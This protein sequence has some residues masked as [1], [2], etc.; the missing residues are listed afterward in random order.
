M[1]VTIQKQRLYIKEE[2]LEAEKY[3]LKPTIHWMD[4]AVV[5]KLQ[6]KTF[7]TDAEAK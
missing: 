3:K 2:N 7:Q 5:K 4:K 6:E 1:N